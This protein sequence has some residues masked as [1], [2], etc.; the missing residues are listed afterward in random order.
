[1]RG[2]RTPSADGAPQNVNYGS[3]V[4]QRLRCGS[5]VARC[6]KL[7]FAAASGPAPDAADQPPYLGVGLQAGR[8]ECKQPTDEFSTAS[9]VA[10][11]I[12]RATQ[13]TPA[14]TAN[15]CVTPYLLFGG[16][17]VTA[18]IPRW[19]IVRGRPDRGS[20]QAPSSPAPRTGCAQS[21]TVGRNTPTLAAIAVFDSRR[22][23]QHDPR[24]LRQS[25]PAP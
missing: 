5:D 9:D 11:V 17:N 2:R 25:G 8:T 22:A 1:V 13:A 6:W 14:A 24:S 4:S 20:S 12:P 19:W 15:Q 18:T 21:I 23:Q 7:G 3:G 16:F 10:V